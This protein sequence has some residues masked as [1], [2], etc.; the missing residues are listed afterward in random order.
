MGIFLLGAVFSALF[1]MAGVFGAA[2]KLTTGQIALFVSAIYTG[3]LILQYPIGWASD[4]Y[5]RRVMV[6]IGAVIAAVACI[7]GATG[8]GGVTGLFVAAFVV[9]GMANPLYAILL[10]YTNDYLQPEDMASASAQLLFVNG[11]GAIGGPLVT[12]WLMSVA[13]PG[14]FFVFLGVL[15]AMLAAYALWRMT[16]RAAVPENETQGRYVVMSPMVTT[17][18]T[19]DVV[20]DGW[21]EEAAEAQDISGKDA[22]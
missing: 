16:R 10:A 22:A 13:G 9:G 6:V 21:E 1:G 18:V 15:M 14:G 20:V 4:R 5:D 11:V 7:V 2:A 17:S 12:G 19:M 8:I 3:G